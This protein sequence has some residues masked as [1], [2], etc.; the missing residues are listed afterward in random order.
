MKFSFFFCMN[1]APFQGKTWY[2]ISA[3]SWH[4][5]TV[6]RNIP[7]FLHDTRLLP[8]TTRDNQILKKCWRI[9]LFPTSYAN[10]LLIIWY[11]V[12]GLNPQALAGEGF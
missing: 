8:T 6:P 5:K 11:P 3:L 1:F 7:S 10:I 12:R 2:Q 9:R 4:L